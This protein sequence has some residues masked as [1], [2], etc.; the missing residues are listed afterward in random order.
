MK[1]DINK[2]LN[3]KKIY[4][5]SK[6]FLDILLSLMALIVFSPILVVIAVA[7][8]LDSK[9][10]ILFKQKRMGLN[11]EYFNILKFRTMRT[12]AP[13]DAATDT[14]KDPKKWI[15]KSGSFLRK[16]SM[17]ELPQLINI[18]K[19]DMSIVGPR[20]ALWNQ[21]KLNKL[22]EENNIHLIKPGLT[23]WA[24]INGRDENNDEEK[25]YWD[26]KYLNKRSFIFDIKCII[27]TVFSIIKKDG[28]IEGEK[29]E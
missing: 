7:I 2:Q 24:Q 28:I 13:K 21:Y 23:G 5:V 27:G 22:R 26:I 8:K 10:P 16:S 19:G 14:L 29:A 20:P 4:L 11:H 25:V 6:R 9:G 1:N 12:D 18:L 17:D 3:E 15:T